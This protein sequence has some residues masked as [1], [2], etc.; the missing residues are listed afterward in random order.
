MLQDQKFVFIIPR[1]L[2]AFPPEENIRRD[3]KCPGALALSGSCEWSL[4]EWEEVSRFT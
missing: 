4:K 3:L 1:Q 2:A